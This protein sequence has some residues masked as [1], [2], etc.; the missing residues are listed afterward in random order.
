MIL[1]YTLPSLSSRI[2]LNVPSAEKPIT[3]AIESCLGNRDLGAMETSNFLTKGAPAKTS[4][5]L[6]FSAAMATQKIP[7]LLLKL[8]Q[9]F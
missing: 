8:H 5:N 2:Y 7:L 9:E 4:K 3:K 6:P 1:E